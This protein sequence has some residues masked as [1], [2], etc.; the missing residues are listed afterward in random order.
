VAREL[1][2]PQSILNL[3]RAL[4]A[5]RDASPALRMGSYRPLYNAPES[6]YVFLR[7]AD[8]QRVLVALNFSAEE[9]RIS[10]P[11]FGEGELVISTQLDRA[12]TV[13]LSDLI[14][15]GDEGVIIE[16]ELPGESN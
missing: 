8:Q 4:L 1:E 15:R 10:L 5:Y 14:L 11:S 7:E 13:D 9:Q 16:I 12:G 3:Y 2:Q 6:C